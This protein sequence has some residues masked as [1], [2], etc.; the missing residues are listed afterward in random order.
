MALLIK[1][2]QQKLKQSEDNFSKEQQLQI[3]R[4]KEQLESVDKELND[5]RLRVKEKEKQVLMKGIGQ[6]TFVGT[7]R[8]VYC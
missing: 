1:E 8:R 4:S 5:L 6:C 2:N 3:Q 7:Y